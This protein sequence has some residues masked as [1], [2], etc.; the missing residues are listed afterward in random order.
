MATGSAADR[1]GAAWRQYY[2]KTGARPPRRALALA[3]D[4]FDAAP[5]PAKRAIDLGC[6]NGRETV[7][8]LARGWS[9]LAIDA[10]P[11]AVAGLRARVAAEPGL[12]PPGAL[13]ARVARFEDTEPP[14][15]ALINSGFALP[16]IPPARFAALWPR[17]LAALAP[18]GR[19]ACQLFGARDSWAGDPTITFHTRAEA[20]ALLAPLRVELFDEE[21]TEATTPRGA[22]KHWH[23]FHIIACKP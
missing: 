23:L 3:L 11:A 18:G 7:A 21:E 19:I 8:M 4:R 20:K 10:E 2:G 5:P 6:G 17:L 22:R 16:L 14:R 13:D 1:T 15:C 12:C 9:V